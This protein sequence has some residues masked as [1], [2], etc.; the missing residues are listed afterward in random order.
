ML[1][2]TKDFRK[3]ELK[4]ADASKVRLKRNQM[5]NPTEAHRTVHSIGPFRWLLRC[6]RTDPIHS[7][8]RSF[9][10]FFSHDGLLPGIGERSGPR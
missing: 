10:D 1:S 5:H 9:W 7:L 3:N 2:S 8:Y 6:L 4:E